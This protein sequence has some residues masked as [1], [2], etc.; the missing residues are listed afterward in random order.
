MQRQRDLAAV[1]Q[2]QPCVLLVRAEHDAGETLAARYG[3]A[4]FG[5]GEVAGEAVPVLRPCQRAVNAGRADFHRPGPRHRIFHVQHGAELVVQQFT[6]GE[7]HLG[8]V[9]AVDHDLHR[10]AVAP[11]HGDAHQL[12]A[13][14]LQSGLDDG[15][16]AGFQA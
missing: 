16:D 14:M 15:G 1:I 8:A 2:P 10:R 3:G 9:R 6:I 12:V 11:E 7:R 5:A 13:Q 4:D